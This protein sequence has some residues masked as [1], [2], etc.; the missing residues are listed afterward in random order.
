MKKRKRPT[1]LPKPS[2]LVLATM[3]LVLFFER[4]KAQSTHFKKQTL[5]KSTRFFRPYACGQKSTYERQK[6]VLGTSVQTRAGLYDFLLT[7]GNTYLQEYYTHIFEYEQGYKKSSLRYNRVCAFI[8]AH[9]F[10]MGILTEGCGIQKKPPSKMMMSSTM[11]WRFQLF[12][13]ENIWKHFD[14]TFGQTGSR[15]N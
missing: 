9:D 15:I 10:L 7:F 11:G 1:A 6:K 3:Q 4:K 12:K 2:K 13:K 5:I 8:T 14:W